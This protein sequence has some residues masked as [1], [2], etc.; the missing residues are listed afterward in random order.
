M[1]SLTLEIAPTDPLHKRVLDAV[2]D[3]IR[4]SKSAYSSRH[5]KWQKAEERALAYLPERE[6]DALRR[7][8]R[9]Q[10]SPQYT[11]IQIPYSYAMLMT[12]H[13]YWT[14]VFM[15]R[16]P[17]QQFSGR[18]GESEQN[19][20]ALEA[21]IDYQVQVGEMLVPWYVWLY[22]V[23]KYGV[24]VMGTYWDTEFTTV[25]EIVEKEE[26][27][28][29]I[30][31]TG[32]KKK[33]KQSRRVMGY[34]GNRNYNVRPFDFFPDPRVSL[35]NFQKGEFC[36]VY[37]RLGWNTILKRK[38]LGYYTNIER[39]RGAASGAPDGD[40]VPGSGQLQLPNSYDFYFNTSEKSDQNKTLQNAMVEAYEC[41]IE[42]VPSDWGL[43]KN[44]LPEKWVF[45]VDTKYT[46]VIGAMPLGMNHDK[47]PWNV[48][49]LEPDGYVIA[50]RGMSEILEPVQNTLDWLLNSHF[51][52][53]RKILN[54]QFLVDPSRVV[55]SDML[56][57]QPGGIIRAKEAAYNTDMRE[58]I[59][60]LQV[61]DVTQTHIRDM[62]VM[63]MIGDQALGVNDSIRGALTGGRKTATEIRSAN[64]FGISRL[65]TSAELF[66]AQG[67]GPQAQMLVQNTQQF[68]DGE[69]MFKIAGDLMQQTNAQ[70]TQ[71]TPDSILGFYDFVP[72]DGTL[73]IDRFAQANL[74][75][76]MFIGLRQMPEIMQ[77]YDMGKL[78]AWI[79]QLAG[80]KNINQFKIQVVPD[81]VAAQQ[82]QAGN[83]VP[84][85]QQP[86]LP[87]SSDAASQ[88]LATPPEPGQV[89]GM[90]TT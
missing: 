87:N 32:N 8:K 66:S 5:E 50:P 54:G 86:K 14:T 74:W 20:Q 22:D 40:R 28:L 71:V 49:V 12:S 39:L 37:T 29:G 4:A 59:S 36:A 67:W 57:P 33:V 84:L 48:I 38:A 85:Q 51:Y 10:G 90:G 56:D 68:Y 77:Q 3:R 30:I 47:F 41:C 43:G 58:A 45:T 7:V 24:G 25:S 21:I 75:R 64:T 31:K 26:M 34:Q 88:A 44:T 65:K 63:Q 53:V 11:T 61:Q 52:N 70:F 81:Q 6:V 69:K 76:E 15:A 78:F 72:V 2:R 82:A 89:S 35:A 27:F 17:V 42:L 9:E 79:A 18:H 73:P 80:L 16:T 19:T 46:T 83:V 1:P 60:Q 13:T 62:Q 55:I 23:G